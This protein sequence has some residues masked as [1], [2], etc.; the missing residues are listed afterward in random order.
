MATMMKT[1]EIGGLRKI[2]RA[3]RTDMEIE[4]ANGVQPSPIYVLRRDG[5]TD[6]YVW[7]RGRVQRS[8]VAGHVTLGMHVDPRD[9]PCIVS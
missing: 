4:A 3:I 5:D 1:T 6:A 8:R 9:L 7:V 2:D